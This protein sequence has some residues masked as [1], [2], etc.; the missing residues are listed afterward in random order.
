MT[1]LLGGIVFLGALARL[2]YVGTA[3]LWELTTREPV[4]L[5]VLVLAV[6]GLATASL[7]SDAFLLPLVA[8]CVSFYLWGQVFL[9]SPNSYAGLGLGYWVPAVAA[10]G[11]SIAGLLAVVAQWAGE[12]RPAGTAQ[13][14]KR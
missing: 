8:T 9:D 4:I 3:T 1:L 6:C 13:I 7:F 2:N 11:M 12:K 14:S 5:T 10:F